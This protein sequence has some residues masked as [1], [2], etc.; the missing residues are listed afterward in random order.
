VFA[1]RAVENR[2][3]VSSMTSRG[4][5]QICVIRVMPCSIVVKRLMALWPALDFMRDTLYDGCV[6]RN[7]N[8]I[9]KRIA[10]ARASTSPSA[11]RRHYLR[12]PV[13]RPAWPAAGNSL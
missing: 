9:D 12:D 1:L 4:D 2:P 3:K 13:D 6:F 5:R 10:E 7:L 8:V 11:S